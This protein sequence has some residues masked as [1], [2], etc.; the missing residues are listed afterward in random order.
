MARR[1]SRKGAKIQPAVKTLLFELNT[2]PPDALVD[3]TISLSQC[4]SLVNRR[5][6]RAG[7]NWAV[8]GFT[9][10]TQGIGEVFVSKI[11]DTWIASNAWHKGMAT[12]MKMNHEALEETESVRP[13]FLDFKVYMDQVHHQAGVANNLIPLD[14]A[15]T[16]FVTGEWEM[17]KY[18]IP[19]TTLGATGGVQDREIIW[20]GGNYPGAAPVSGLNSVS[21]IDGYSAS[22]ALPDIV[23]PNVPDDAADTDGVSP[24]NW[25]AAVFNEGTQQSDEILDTMIDEN[26]QA[27]YPFENDG[28]NVDTMYPGGPN[29]APGLQIHDTS[30]VTATTIG[31]KSS[32]SGTNFQGGL[33]RISNKPTG[34]WGA[35]PLVLV[36]LVPGP[37]RGY[38]TQPMQDV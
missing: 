13:R 12:W 28:V 35:A 2:G 34:S 36:H 26:N 8:A 27:P 32:I 29:Q 22:R 15:G 19:D 9:V 14:H 18:V 11:P 7:L 25:L 3:D 20:T 17:S 16:S 33:I 21:L 31:G 6:Y 4:A 30:L 5:F 1:R 37:A 10:L 23:D 24:E 38:M